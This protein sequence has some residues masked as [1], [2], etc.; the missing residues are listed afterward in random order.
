MSDSAHTSFHYLCEMAAL[1]Q[2]AELSLP[3]QRDNRASAW[4]G[5]GFRVGGQYCVAPMG[6]I[7]EVLHEPLATRLP[8]VQSWVRGV[9]NVRGRLL[10]LIDLSAFL[11]MAPC[12]RGRVL[13]LERDE[14]YT[15]LIVE[16]VLGMQHFDSS[17]YAD[18][19]GPSDS[20]LGKYLR[21]S[22]RQG[23]REWLVF[24][25]NRLLNDRDF[26]QVAA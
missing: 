12:L 25:P 21:G 10:P 1:A 16:E 9:A 2:A 13:V 20:A 14:I 19:E 23:D 22:Y 7:T 4:S 6:D 8:G 5:I 17:L 26:F 18:G 3:S 11:G 15:G 24:R